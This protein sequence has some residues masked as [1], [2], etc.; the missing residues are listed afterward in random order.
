MKLKQ[1]EYLLKIVECGSITRAA[2]ELYISQPSLTK[3]IVSLEEEYN[4]QILIRKPRGVELTSDGKNFV[5]Y[6]R[7][8]LAA[9]NALEQNFTDMQGTPR[10]RLFLATQQL[11]FVHDLFFRTYLQ[12]QDKR[13][14]YNL[15]ET[16]R[17][18]VTRQ[19]LS[20]NV[21]LGLLVR[22]V[23][24]A[25][26][27][28]VNAEAKRLSVHSI[29]R[30]GVYAAVGPYSP[31]YNRQIITFE[32]AENCPQ[33]VLDMEAQ[34]TQNLYFDNVSNHFNTDK[35]IFVN[36]IRAC[37]Q[38]LVQSELLLFVAKW[39]EGCFRDPRIRVI[40]VEYSDGENPGEE[41]NELLWIKRAGEP[42]NFTEYQFL[43]LLY[44][45][46]GKEE[47]LNEL[48]P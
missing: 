10:S 22:N 4:I 14:H 23:A 34:A 32:E 41:I 24:D 43:R 21:D 29:S 40:P 26:T 9:A 37:E 5:Y 30:S 31:F 6:A 27:F 3:S 18:D 17:N 16:D 12:N 42:L 1:L 19:V 25:K 28:L 35:I 8:V 47:D 36:S 44:H 45:R 46:F 20:G 2:R 11:D 15:V 39:A 38:F 33:L 13:V 48:L 7:S